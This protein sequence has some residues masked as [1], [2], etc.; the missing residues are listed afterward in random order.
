MSTKYLGFQIG[1]NIPSE[2]IIALVIHSIGQKL[3]HW[4]SKKLSLAGRIIT[5]Q[6]RYYSQQHGTI[7]HVGPSPRKVY[8]RFSGWYATTFGMVRKIMQLGP[9]VAWPIL[10][11]PKLR[12]GFGLIDPLSQSKVL[13]TKICGVRTPT[14]GYQL[15]S[16]VLQLRFTYFRPRKGVNSSPQ[17]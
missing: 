9:R 3:I 7:Y 13:L 8:T 17:T 11:S 14:R 2:T 10:T 12:G 5:W 15:E 1:F 4:S 6:T 16:V